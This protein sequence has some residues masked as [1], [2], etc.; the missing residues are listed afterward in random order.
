MIAKV[1]TTNA[2]SVMLFDT[3]LCK[4]ATPSASRG[5]A[6]DKLADTVDEN[7]GDCVKDCR[8][9]NVELLDV[10]ASTVDGF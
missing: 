2:V 4:G 1:P 6:Y 3:I 8:R 9:P 10:D 5:P 7:E